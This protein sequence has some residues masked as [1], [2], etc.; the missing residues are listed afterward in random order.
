MHSGTEGEGFV[1]LVGNTDSQSKLNKSP[2]IEECCS[3]LD[4]IKIGKSKRLKCVRFR[5]WRA[6]ECFALRCVSWAMVIEP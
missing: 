5:L 2:L 4:L 6:L 1:S 3:G